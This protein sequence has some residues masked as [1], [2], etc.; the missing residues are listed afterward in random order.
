LRRLALGPAL[1]SAISIFTLQFAQGQTFTVIHSFEGP[2]GYV[3][4]AGLTMDRAGNFYGTTRDGGS[5][6]NGPFCSVYAEIGC[7]T[8][9]KLSRHGSDWQLSPIFLFDGPDGP[10]WYRKRSHSARL[11]QEWWDRRGGRCSSS[12]YGCGALFSLT[13]P[14]RNPRSVVYSWTELLLHNFTGN[15][16]GGPRPGAL[17]FDSAGNMYGTSFWGGPTQSGLVFEFTPSGDNWTENVL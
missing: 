2:D 11:S 12:P 3:P 13:P 6:N 17:L 5:F 14:A 7:G 15:N 1:L 16:D 10:K 4:S 8:V 9:F